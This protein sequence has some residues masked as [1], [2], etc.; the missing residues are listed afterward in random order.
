MTLTGKNWSTWRKT[1]PTDTLSAT[2]LT[3]TDLGANS[4]RLFTWRHHFE[5]SVVKELLHL[6][7]K[8][9][10]STKYSLQ[11]EGDSRSAGCWRVHEGPPIQCSLN[12]THYLLQVHFNIIL[13]TNLR[14]CDEFSLLRSRFPSNILYQNIF[15]Y[16]RRILW[17]YLRQ[18]RPPKLLLTSIRLFQCTL[19]I[20]N[21]QWEST[22]SIRCY[23]E[24]KATNYQ[25]RF[26]R[27]KYERGREDKTAKQ[28][29]VRRENP[30]LTGLSDWKLLRWVSKSSACV[31]RRV[32]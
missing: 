8:V 11:W 2:N 17:G 22:W 18:S 15:V 1:R 7:P 6:I 23:S 28:K 10:Q 3:W 30:V 21:T 27:Y 29:D 9:I 32:L 16:N 26:D 19:S 12:L 24:S 31:L 14:V 5:W 4:G 20:G 13:Y 25:L